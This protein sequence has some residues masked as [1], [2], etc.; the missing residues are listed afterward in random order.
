ML[1]KSNFLLVVAVL[2]AVQADGL[3]AQTPATPTVAPQ[4]LPPREVSAADQMLAD[5]LA[6]IIRDAI[7]RE[8][9]KKKDWGHTKRITT[10]VTADGPVYQF[11]LHRTKKEVPHGTWKQYRVKFLEP[12]EQLKVTVENLHSLEGSG[13]GLR[14]VVEARLEGWAQMREY[15]R[16]I[17]LITLTAEGK[18]QLKLA[19]DCEV[20]MQ[21]TPK[22][23]AI[24]P[25]VTHATLDLQQFELYRFGE[26]EGKLA[27]ELGDGLQHLLEDQLES[28]KLKAKLNRAIE[29]KRDRLV[30]V[31]FAVPAKK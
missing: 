4:V 15:N 1:Y 8:Y 12:D 9:E 6:S 11:K 19:I 2:L 31:P 25:E 10:G 30:L 13:I 26:V 29:K 23:M 21:A 27:H 28:E 20:R 22:G 14:L 16:G 24:V 7:P 3:H 5:T 17:H 18:S